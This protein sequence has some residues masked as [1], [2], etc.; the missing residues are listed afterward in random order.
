MAFSTPSLTITRTASAALLIISFNSRSRAGANSDKTN[1]ALSAGHLLLAD[2]EPD[3]HDRVTLQRGDHRFQAV[4]TAGRTAAS[5]PDSAE[6]QVQ[7]VEDQD[8]RLRRTATFR[9]EQPHR[10]TAQVHVGQRLG[11]QTPWPLDRRFADHRPAADR[12]GPRVRSARPAR[13]QP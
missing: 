2:P 7:V 8:E 12:P 4:M 10:M 6:R 3:A 9:E 1:P 13:R 11:Q 5:D